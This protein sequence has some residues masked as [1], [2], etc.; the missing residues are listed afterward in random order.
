MA[1]GEICSLLAI[2]F[3]HIVFKGRLVQSRQ[4]AST[5]AGPFQHSTNLQQLTEYI[6]YMQNNIEILGKV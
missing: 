3:F 5:W 4:L 2:F 6:I 1:K